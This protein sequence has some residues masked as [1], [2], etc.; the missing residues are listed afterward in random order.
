VLSEEARAIGH[1]FHYANLALRGSKL[2]VIIEEQ[3]PRALRLQPDLVTI[4]AGSNDIMSKPESLPALRQLLSDGVE[5]LLAAGC[6]VVLVNI[7]NLAHLKVLRPFRHKAQLFSEVIETVADDFDIPLLDVHGIESF[8][9]VVYWADDMVH[10]SGHG[11]IKVAN[12]AA[13]LLDLK[14]RYPE[15]DPA[16]LGPVTRGLVQTAKWVGRDVIPFFQ[17]RLQGRT[18]GDGMLPKHLN[19]TPY[20]PPVNKPGWQLV[21]V[22]AD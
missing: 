7:V 13:E 14:Y 10:F 22:G 5:Q 16:E 4:M 3:L 11:H 1:D 15:S 19:L 18:S 9:D 8:E 17:R 21:S 6:D 2:R 12:K 20:T